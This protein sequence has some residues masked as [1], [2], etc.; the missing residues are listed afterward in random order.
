MKGQDMTINE[1]ISTVKREKPNQFA[2][3]HLIQWLNEVESLVQNKLGIMIDEWFKYS[4]D[5]IENETELI[6]SPP[7]DILYVYWLKAKIDY[8]N[9]D[10]E[11]FGNN[12]AQFQSHFNEFLAYAHRNGLVTSRL[13]RKFKNV[14]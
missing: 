14:F 3:E 6:V 13:P 10:Y 2:N 4:V 12:Q 11:S 7:Y 9:E 8:T 5:D 1:V